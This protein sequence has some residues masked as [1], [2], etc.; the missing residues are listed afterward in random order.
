MAGLGGQPTPTD[1][2]GQTKKRETTHLDLRWPCHVIFMSTCR[3][4]ARQ[5]VSC[6]G[7]SQTGCQQMHISLSIG[8]QMHTILS[9][10]SVRLLPVDTPSAISLISA[11]YSP[12][13]S[14]RQTGAIRSIPLIHAF[15]RCRCRISPLPA[16]V[17]G[18]TLTPSCMRGASRISLQSLACLLYTSPSPRD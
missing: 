12:S 10:H 4:Q 18:S 17:V 16:P 14:G 13:K 1:G 3:Q 15:P 6:G 7:S 5:F 9:T 2:S 11:P 8:Y